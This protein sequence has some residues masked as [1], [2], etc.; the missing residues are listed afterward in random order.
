[1]PEVN[2]DR[3]GSNKETTMRNVE[4]YA[5]KILPHALSN[6]VSSDIQAEFNKLFDSL[7]EKA[8]SAIDNKRYSDAIDILEEA[9]DAA[10]GI[11]WVKLK[12]S[13]HHDG[14]VDLIRD[15]TMQEHVSQ[16]AAA[17][18]HVM[19]LVRCV[20]LL[21]SAEEVMKTTARGAQA[22]EKSHFIESDISHNISKL[23]R[24]KKRDSR[25][26]EQEDDS[27]SE[28]QK[29]KQGVRETEIFKCNK[30][31]VEAIQDSVSQKINGG[32]SFEEQ[33]YIASLRHAIKV[34]SGVKNKNSKMDWTRNNVS[35]QDQ[36]YHTTTLTKQND[37]DG[38]PVIISE[39]SIMMLGFTRAQ[40]EA[41]RKIHESHGKKISLKDPNTGNHKDDVE[42]KNALEII[43]HYNKMSAKQRKIISNAAAEHVMN[44]DRVVPSC[45]DGIDCIKNPRLDV[46]VAHQEFRAPNKPPE[47][48]S[49]EIGHS[50]SIDGLNETLKVTAS[51][52][53]TKDTRERFK[54]FFSGQQPINSRMEQLK[55]FF[56]DGQKLNIT[57]LGEPRLKLGLV[58]LF[59]KNRLVYNAVNSYSKIDSSVS[60]DAA[61][62]KSGDFS[63]LE[64]AIKKVG[65]FIEK[66]CIKKSETLKKEVESLTNKAHK[67][68]A[69]STERLKVE[70]QIQL[71]HERKRNLNDI[72]EI[73]G[74]IA[75]NTNA[76]H[77]RDAIALCNSLTGLDNE[78]V[79]KIELA[80]MLEAIR[81]IKRMSSGGIDKS[82]RAQE[83]IALR[84]MVMDA[85]NRVHA[86][87]G[88]KAV[89]ATND[90]INI[91]TSAMVGR[92]ALL[93]LRSA[94]KSVSVALGLSQMNASEAEMIKK[95]CKSHLAGGHTKHAVASMGM[96]GV[97]GIDKKDVKGMLKKADPIY[98]AVV[99]KDNTSSTIK[100][101]NKVIRIGIKLFNKAKSFVKWVRGS[102]YILGVLLKIALAIVI[103]PVKFIIDTSVEI[104]RSINDWMKG[105]RR[106]YY[107][108]DTKHFVCMITPQSE[109]VKIVTRERE[110][111]QAGLEQGRS[112]EVKALKRSDSMPNLQGYPEEKN[113]FAENVSLK[114]SSSMH[115]LQDYPEEKNPFVDGANQE[116]S[117]SVSSL[118]TQEYPE[119]KNPF[120]ESTNQKRNN[121]AASLKVQGGPEKKDSFAD[122]NTAQKHSVSSSINN[123]SSKKQKSASWELKVTKGSLGSD[124]HR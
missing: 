45:S 80:Q 98:A 100:N 68:S 5:K 111:Q 74:R 69:G 72:K 117:N 103:I 58:N 39:S 42:Y 75:S 1:M 7:L 120:V 11:K 37:R 24:S 85:V 61:S 105:E 83:L 91:T 112:D 52:V 2:A 35:I 102:H 118:K 41:Y 119:E 55:G 43:S 93:S 47:V 79:S 108:K 10:C 87:L 78:V 50:Y 99:D 57:I 64:N 114:R 90:V 22:V 17:Q 95:N 94:Q 82:T 49:S 44:Q 121:S 30:V 109:E 56:A 9:K 59:S 51:K 38:I 101:Q 62:M 25:V 67:M 18:E 107:K 19:K 26:E 65:H 20:S 86:K 27:K 116:R 29:G 106:S 16:D 32:Y 123:E 110:S 40:V 13:Q 6:E 4:E 77:L 21:R 60:V 54:S 97:Q 89:E 31:L 115:N 3:L 124:V 28:S 113:H 104:Y 53:F 48:K 88:T 76:N 92:T 84:P 14:S 33:D 73:A 70:S 15:A 71:I 34:E 36:Q 63:D 8:A 46:I 23:S 66:D 122:K 12:D 96:K 81:L